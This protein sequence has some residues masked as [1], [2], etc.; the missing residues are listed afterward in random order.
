M[1]DQL[2]HDRWRGYHLVI[3][4]VLLLA[5]IFSS[6]FFHWLL[7][8]A[9]VVVFILIA[10]AVSWSER[11]FRRHLEKYIQTLSHRVK[12]VGDEALLEMPIGIILYNE[13]HNIEWMNHYMGTLTDN[14]SLLSQSLNMVSEDLV[15]IITGES[16]K[17]IIDIKKHKYKVTLRPEERLIYLFEVTDLVNLQNQYDAEKTEI[18]R[19][20]V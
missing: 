2:K 16:D 7:G 17:A 9:G 15:P 1:S 8:I 13:A 6:F 19:A 4:C 18:G 3:P 5:F 10:I 12:K 20:H 14:D 11:H